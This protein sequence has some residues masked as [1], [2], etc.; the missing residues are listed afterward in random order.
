MRPRTAFSGAKG[1]TDVPKIVDC[2]MDGQNNIDDIIKHTMPLDD[3][4]NAF[5]LMRAG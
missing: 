4:D 3:I 1:R 2:D 5:D